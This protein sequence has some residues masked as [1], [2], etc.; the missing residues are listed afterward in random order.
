MIKIVVSPY[1]TIDD[2]DDNVQIDPEYTR[3]TSNMII[4]DEAHMAIMRGDIGSGIDVCILADAF[5]LLKQRDIG[6]FRKLITKNKD[7]INDKH[8]GTFL[9]HESCQRG[10]PECAALL[11]FLGAKCSVLNDK[12]L[13][14]QH[15]AVLSGSTVLIDILSLFGHS[16]NII[17]V[18]KK[19]PFQYAI[20]SKNQ[21]MIKTMMI[22][23]SDPFI[24]PLNIDDDICDDVIDQL[25][26]YIKDYK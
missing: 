3:D 16:M 22:Y 17:G 2:D 1:I 24:D 6:K 26:E 10:L 13:S 15:C 4:S 23:K 18:D 5:N 7:I 8:L 19:T 21:E 14:A 20:D 12:G 9:I 25:D 11:L